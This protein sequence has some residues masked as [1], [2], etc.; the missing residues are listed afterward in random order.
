[1]RGN[2]ATRG[3]L[4][5]P[6]T[7]QFRTCFFYIWGLIQVNRKTPTFSN[8]LWIISNSLWIR[9]LQ[10]TQGKNLLALIFQPMGLP[11][12][13]IEGLI[14]LLFD[15][16]KREAEGTERKPWICVIPT[17][18]YFGHLKARRTKTSQP[19]SREKK[20]QPETQI[21]KPGWPWR[22]QELTSILEKK[23]QNKILLTSTIKYSFSTLWRHH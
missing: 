12:T 16:K 23:S 21:L 2:R 4:G 15:E 8:S 9:P 6:H 18:P 13:I 10:R 14:P 22:S 3:C 19:F 7:I 1:M 11:M 5:D 20:M 17:T